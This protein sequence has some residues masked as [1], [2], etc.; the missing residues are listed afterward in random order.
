MTSRSVL[1]NFLHTSSIARSMRNERSAGDKTLTKAQQEIL[2]KELKNVIIDVDAENKQEER[3]E[4]NHSLI[5]K[6][7]MLEEMDIIRARG[8][9]RYNKK[10]EPPADI[11]NIVK[12]VCKSNGIALC[13]Q[14]WQATKLQ[15]LKAKS[16]I[17]VDLGTTLGHFVTNS[18]LHKLKCLSDVVQFYSEPVSNLTKY[19]QMARD[20]RLPANIAIR[21]HA[22]IFH[23][24]DKH[25]VHGRISAYPEEDDQALVGRNQHNQKKEWFDYEDQSFDYKPVDKGMPW[26]PEIAKKMDRYVDRKFLKNT[27][28]KI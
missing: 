13:E 20:D 22:P 23:P 24:D 15:D 9:M 21:E 6:P 8:I 7:N 16:K 25:G 4:A 19:A 28:K 27:V 14:E 3:V 18:H 2:R 5:K 10:Y 1:K 11:A 12:E 17:L 26:D